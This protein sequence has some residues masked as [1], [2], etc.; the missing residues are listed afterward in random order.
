MTNLDIPLPDSNYLNLMNKKSKLK[1][2]TK[3]PPVFHSFDFGRVLAMS[4]RCTLTLSPRP[5]QNIGRTCRGLAKSK[6]FCC[7]GHGESHNTCSYFIILSDSSQS[8]HPSNHPIN[9]S[10]NQS[11]IIGMFVRM[12]LDYQDHPP[13]KKKAYHLFSLSTTQ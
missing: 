3:H 7:D 9:Q 2:E 8:V 11:A 1:R 6:G 4:V 13:N 10:T 12:I 5:S